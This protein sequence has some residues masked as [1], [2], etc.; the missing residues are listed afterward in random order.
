MST[1]KERLS[2]LE[3][4]VNYIKETVDKIDGKVD[5]L[6]AFKLKVMGAASVIAGIV[7]Y[8]TAVMVN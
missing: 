1:D 3:T 8:I 5:D 6:V 7:A 4:H 2:T